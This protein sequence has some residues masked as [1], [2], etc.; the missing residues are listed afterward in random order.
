MRGKG[1]GEI[2]GN[3]SCAYSF[4]TQP[5]QT[6]D[7]TA[8]TVSISS[9]ASG[10]TYTTAQRVVIMAS[11]SDNIGVT[12]VDFYDDT[13]FVV[14]NAMA[15]YAIGW[16]ITSANNGTHNW[17]ARA[18]DAA[19]NVKTSAVVSLTVNIP[20]ADATLPTVTIT[21]PTGS[22]TYLT[23][24]GAV[25]LGGSASDN[26]GVTQVTWSNDRGGSGT[27]SGT[28]AWTANGISLQSGV[29]VITITVRDA[30]GNTVTDALTV[31]YNP[32][33]VESFVQRQLPAGYT[34]GSAFT[35]TLRT[36]PPTGALAYGVEE[37]PPTGWMVE[38]I[39]D[40]GAYD[41]VNRKVKWTFL[42]S[43][44]RTLT[45]Q[46]TPP[47]TASGTQTFQGEGNL[48]G[49]DK[50]VIGGMT[51]INLA[52]YHPADVNPANWTVPL[53]EVLS[54]ATAFKRGD[55]WQVPPNPI[56]IGYVIRGF[57]LY[58][59][60]ERYRFDSSQASA[61][62]WWVSDP[63]QP[64]GASVGSS[65]T[66]ARKSQVAPQTVGGNT[67]VGQ[68]P[69]QYT[70]GTPLTVA[71][72]VTPES[73][74]FACGVEDQPPTGWTVGSINEN[75]AFDSVSRKVKWTFLDSVRRTLT[76]QATPPIGASGAV[77]FTG[78]ANFDGVR[79]V[80]IT[81]QRSTTLGPG[82][83]AP[84]ITGQPQSQTVNA[85]ANVTFGV[86]AT[87]DA[88]LS[89]QWRKDGVMIAGA[90]STIL[91]FASVNSSNAGS[92][93]VV[94]SNSAGSVTS[95][96]ATLTV[97]PALPPLAVAMT[98]SPNPAR[99]G[100]DVIYTITVANRGAVD[101]SGV[102]L[103]ATLPTYLS[104]FGGTLWNLGTLGTGQSQ[105]VTLKARVNTAPDG[106]VVQV[107]A[108]ATVASIGW[109]SVG[110]SSIRLGYNWPTLAAIEN[111]IV[112]QGETITFT[113]IA[114]DA[115][116]PSQTLRFVLDPGAPEGSR[117]DQATGVF[118]WTPTRAQA[119]ST[120]SITV[121]ATDSSPQ[122]LS[123]T[124]TF[125]VVVFEGND[126]PVITAQPGNQA[127]T[128][129]ASASFKVA[130]SGMP[131][132]TLRWQVSTSSGNSWSDLA[133]DDL[134]SGVTTETLSI[135]GAT[136]A[137]NGFQYRCVATNGSGS[138]NST[139]AV[140]T[141]NPVLTVPPYS[142]ST[143]SLI[144]YG[145]PLSAAQL[146]A[147]S[148]VA[149]VTY[150]DNP[151]GTI[152]NAGENTIKATLT[153][154]GTNAG[155]YS[156]A[157]VTQ[158]LLVNKATPILAWNKPADILVGTPLSSIQL[159][160]S[161]TVAGQTVSGQFGYSPPVGTILP[162]GDDQILGVFFVP[163]DLANIN[164][165]SGS[166]SI[167]VRI[168]AATRVLGDMDSDGKPDL[169]FQ[170]SNGTLATWL[171]DGPKLSSAR[172]LTPAN[173]GDT[174]WR[175][176]GSADFNGDGKEDILF[177]HTDGTL[178]V[179]SMNGVV[180]TAANLLN[181]SRPS[182]P[183]WRVT[184]TGD[185]NSDGKT[186]L[187]FQHKDG[188]LAAWLLS[189]ASLT[190]AALFNPSTP[191]DVNWRVAGSGDFDLDGN[192][193]LLFQHEDGTMAV[194]FLNGVT[195]LRASLLSPSNPGTVWRVV[196]VVDRNADGKPDLLFQHDKGTLAVWFMDGIR[197]KDAKILDPA[198]PGG[199]WKV[200]AP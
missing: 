197:L 2:Y 23:G 36:T 44:A 130:V 20:E 86:S 161:A 168:T 17:T 78:T 163:D 133:N 75:G 105:T 59:T 103:S 18:Y 142:W 19:G 149:A 135:I 195:L 66:V 137:L 196:S 165:A 147:T 73:G 40:S 15:P 79:E 143:P 160:A 198:N 162:E 45:Y 58:L 49:T 34:P 26:A 84:T 188:T 102:S 99:P 6:P 107:T 64:Q 30:A 52:A 175:V 173:V 3:W 192:P 129:G 112:N 71:I 37:Q 97:G 16:A 65:S 1:P 145:T 171:M 91:T 118:I 125:T 39:S 43:I 159:N 31:T 89:Y 70:P 14:S 138:T 69:S 150:P 185:F 62:A 60:G 134:Y 98:A 72:V 54:Y 83:Q 11:A 47:P 114:A 33:P 141:V 167:N 74:T 13:T 124:Q 146:N 77:T 148:T 154:T 122:Q 182:D 81:G 183:N 158:V 157:V 180:L 32:P 178:A 25:N 88:P 116:Q 8:P 48:N 127:V 190:S 50:S 140:L 94:V 121:R 166:A 41:S 21:S 104:Y 42:E 7:T 139:A 92:Y 109:S 9:P 174:N 176:A 38:T 35:V 55:T 120:N 29:N 110:Q 4:T 5:A 93:T 186:D 151:P 179:W 100:Q 67:A 172:F 46:V 111:L 85:G 96:P 199:T 187:V 101:L 27:A 24:S 51:T 95:N 136:I 189:G 181:P 56:P 184:A 128:A 68:L 57:A 170:D 131:M 87:G 153:P 200:V 193:D 119:P 12:K 156:T 61:P 108:V 191:G 90:N 123:T 22:S 10:T 28:T 63:P 106:T 76:Y 155:I 194:W 126:P 144:T 132:P 53:S 113:A 152:L 115:D 169:L 80:V 82:I 117:I 177:Q 164:F